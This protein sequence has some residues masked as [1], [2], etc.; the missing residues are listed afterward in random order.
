MMTENVTNFLTRVNALARGVCP[1]DE[2][3]NLATEPTERHG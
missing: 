2:E 3:G 1:T